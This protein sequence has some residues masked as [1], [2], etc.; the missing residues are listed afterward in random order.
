MVGLFSGLGALLA[1]GVFLP[2]PARL[3]DKPGWTQGHAV[4]VA[5]WIVAA[6][7]V[8]AAVA[9]ATGLPRREGIGRASTWTEVKMW[10]WVKIWGGD[11]YNLHGHDADEAGGYHDEER[12]G[13]S[14]LTGLWE[15]VKVG[16]RDGR[17]LVGY[18]GGFVARASSVGISLFIPLVV[19][20]WFVETGQCRPVTDPEESKRACRNAYILA[21]SMLSS[22][23]V[24]WG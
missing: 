1:L 8:V 11:P 4:V 16:G 17:I 15:A 5:Y 14:G 22:S 12:R 19:N 3:A 13:T 6:V 23:S 7:A 18:V 21:S 9:C 20:H 24:H 10:A 2:L